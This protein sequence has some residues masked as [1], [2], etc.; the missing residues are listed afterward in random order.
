MSREPK[1]ETVSTDKVFFR[2]KAEGQTVSI[3]MAKP[4]LEAK[5]NFQLMIQHLPAEVEPETV[6][7]GLRLFINFFLLNTIYRLPCP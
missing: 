2:E 5:L 3:S 1:C 7:Q 4:E 6:R